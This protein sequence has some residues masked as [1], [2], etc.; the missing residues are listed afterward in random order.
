MRYFVLLCML[1]AKVFAFSSAVMPGM[2][3]L[4]FT[5]QDVH[6]QDVSLHDYAG[7][8]VVLEWRDPRCDYVKK[9][10]TSNKK[11]TLQKHYQEQFGVVWL[12]ILLNN[13]DPLPSA[14]TNVLLDPAREVTRLYDVQKVPEIIVID[15]A[16]YVAYVGAVDSVRS[17]DVVDVARARANY[18]EMTLD[19][20][21]SSHPVPISHT[22]PFGCQ[23]AHYTPAQFH[24]V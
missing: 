18:I 19:A 11:Q 3:A 17:P 22:R 16:G 8:I 13:D 15:E 6:G 2:H 20:L 5:L 1:I 12:T 10:Y 14:A 24:R 9:Y 21:V 7:K 4:D 23:T